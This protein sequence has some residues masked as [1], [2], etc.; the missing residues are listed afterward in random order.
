MTSLLK[1]QPRLRA[2]TSLANLSRPTSITTAR[3]TLAQKT[4]GPQGEKDSTK[5][6]QQ[7]ADAQSSYPVPSN[8]AEPTLRDGKASPLADEDGTLRDDLPEDVKKHNQEMEER[9]DRPYNQMA[10]EGK[11]EPGWKR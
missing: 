11:V 9:Y 10:E 8:K 3:R 6:R 5:T 2:P 1:L 7:V 4:S